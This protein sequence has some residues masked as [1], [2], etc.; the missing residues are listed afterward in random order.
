VKRGP[1]ASISGV[2][3]LQRNITRLGIV[4][5][6]VFCCVISVTDFYAGVRARGAG[7]PLVRGA[8]RLP[9]TSSLLRDHEQAATVP[10][11]NP[12]DLLAL[13]EIR[14]EVANRTFSKRRAASLRCEAQAALVAALKL[15]P[16]H[17]PALA[18]LAFLRSQQ[19]PSANALN[20]CSQLA[21]TLKNSPVE[22]ARFAVK[23]DPLNQEV[24]STAAFVL[25][26][27][28]QRQEAR[29]V[30]RRALEL[31]TPMPTSDP[32]TLLTYADSYEDL[33]ALLPRRLS[34]V[35]A[36]SERLKQVDGEAFSRWGSPLG[37]VQLETLEALSGSQ[38]TE[39][40]A[41][42]LLLRLEQS[43]ATPKA[44]KAIHKLL[45]K[46]IHD[47]RAVRFYTSLAALERM[48]RVPATVEPSSLR[49]DG[50]LT[51]WNRSERVTLDRY[52]SAVGFFVPNPEAVR[53]VTLRSEKTVT[54]SI[55]PLLKVFVS[56]NNHSWTEVTSAL[57]VSA[58]PVDRHGYV[59]ISL[60][61]EGLPS[62]FG[63]PKFW[64]VY[65]S[66]SQRNGAFSGTL[67]DMLEVYGRAGRPSVE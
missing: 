4:L 61:S 15:E 62:G 20:E 64:K 40:D 23:T 37:R 33:L 44:L 5:S 14:N 7:R 6:A 39:E 57:T 36:W 1:Y 34:V 47:D 49:R 52:Y 48:P 26:K 25:S 29:N 50:A 3:T 31:E 53:M 18:N 55:V 10:L 27:A 54:G 22:L 8:S 66:G 67:G 63:K 51:A 35:A 32:L 65:F 17:G 30:I 2:V 21:I 24:L 59:A 45:A 43:A 42:P 38:A 11:A 41:L 60:P 12:G 16:N 9:V 19:A 28:G 56:E 13:S 58:I 46:T